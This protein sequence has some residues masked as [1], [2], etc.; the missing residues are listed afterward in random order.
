MLRETI[1][2]GLAERRVLQIMYGTEGLRDV[3]PH[4]ILR[5]PDGTE[6]LEG[7]QLRGASAKGVEHGWRHFDI[8]RITHAEPLEEHFEPRRDFK[9]VSGESGQIVATVRSA[10]AVEM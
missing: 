2:R 5:K 9:P 10:E 4:A 7:Y 1:L 6:L 8:A 3:Q